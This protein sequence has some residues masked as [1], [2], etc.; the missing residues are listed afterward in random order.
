MD[1]RLYPIE[2]FDEM[3]LPIIEKSED[4]ERIKY[5]VKYYMYYGTTMERST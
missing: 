3:I 2:K 4:L 5:S 1:R